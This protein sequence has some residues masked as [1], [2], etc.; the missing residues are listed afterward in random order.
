MH[1]RYYAGSVEDTLKK[2]NSDPARGLSHKEARSRFTRTFRSEERELYYVPKRSLFA[3][4]SPCLSDFSFWLL[5]LTSGTLA[6]FDQMGLAALSALFLLL[7]LLVSVVL[8]QVSARLSERM[9]RGFRPKVKVIREG[10][11]YF[12]DCRYVVRGDIVLL[13]RG[14]N[15]P[16]DA[17]LITAEELTVSVRTGKNENGKNVF[18]VRKKDPSVRL[19]GRRLLSI[20]E[21]CNMVTAGSLILSGSARAVV[22]ETG[23]YTYIGALTGG[24]PIESGNVAVGDSAT[25]M[26][27]SRRVG[28]ILLFLLIPLTVVSYFFGAASDL[29]VSFLTV[30]SL[31]STVIIGW[32]V[33]LLDLFTSYK[34]YRFVMRKN[35]PAGILF[36]S[37]SAF[38]RLASVDLLALFDRTMLTDGRPHVI[39]VFSEGRTFREGKLRN[40]AC[41]VLAEKALL[42]RKREAATPTEDP[43]SAFASLTEF[44]GRELSSY[45]AYLEVDAEALDIR[46]KVRAYHAPR[47]NRPIALLEYAETVN[48][49]ERT[50][51]LCRSEGE[52][53]FLRATRIRIAGEELPLTD[54]GRKEIRTFMETCKARGGRISCYAEKNTA[55]ELVFLGLIV[56]SELVV[57]GTRAALSSLSALGVRTVLFSE[58]ESEAERHY[59]RTSG[60]ISSDAE[61]ALASEFR[62]TGRAITDGFGTFS[63]YLGFSPKEISTL[64]TTLE[65][66]KIRVA[67]VALRD[68]EGALLDG[69]SL[70]VAC[71]D[72]A[73]DRNRRLERELTELPISGVRHGT[74]ASEA[75]KETADLLV[76]RASPEGGGLAALLSAV[77]FSRHVAVG[78]KRFLAFLTL[79]VSFFAGWVLPVLLMAR[80]LFPALLLTASGLC[81]SVVSGALVLFLRPQS[82]DFAPWFGASAYGDGISQGRVML[83]SV[84]GAAL[85]LLLALFPILLPYFT[86]PSPR[87]VGTIYVL[88]VLFFHIFGILYAL[89]SPRNSGRK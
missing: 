55:G 42:L 86:S 20:E 57:K 24:I 37:A 38:D 35:A 13:S 48:G 26:R 60:I 82:E 3:S 77:T 21:E 40:E 49:E 11:L 47:E 9:T 53:L 65:E 51:V 58:S 2:L 70:R 5:L 74:E 36:R 76:R 81:L 16:F 73:I 12:T 69:L 29:S 43:S 10:R 14:D 56:Y 63:L 6:F 30:L 71:G 54:E 22:T 1:R 45:A 50:A 66:N 17:R 62:R 88:S 7:N 83:Q 4:F 39:G 78:R 44:L 59:A 32:A 61:I 80:N 75:V 68:E 8:S 89:R 18:V 84:V 72:G 31:L 33:A 41:R 79:H 64:L 85:G 25:V 87:L 23:T 67:G 28:M 27:F 34:A 52:E 15:V 19:D 46:Y